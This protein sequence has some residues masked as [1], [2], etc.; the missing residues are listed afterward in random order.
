MHVCMYA[1]M[2]VCIYA[3]MYIWLYDYIINT[4]A[5]IN[6]YVYINVHSYTWYTYPN[7]WMHRATV[8]FQ[9]LLSAWTRPSHPGA[10]GRCP[11][12]RTGYRVVSPNELLPWSWSYYISADNNIYIHIYMC[13]YIYIMNIQ[14]YMKHVKW[15]LLVYR[16]L[17]YIHTNLHAT[18]ILTNMSAVRNYV[19]NIY[20]QDLVKKCRNWWLRGPGNR[21]GSATGCLVHEAHINILSSNKT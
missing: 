15:I 8:F 10:S 7:G 16:C 4:I 19:I 13:I 17:S 3:C 1:C 21:T 9:V 20:I 14:V 11:W 18:C 2:H 5:Y 6:M 12:L